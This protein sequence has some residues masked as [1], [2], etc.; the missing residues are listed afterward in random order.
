MLLGWSPRRGGLCLCTWGCFLAIYGVALNCLDLSLFP[1]I[2]TGFGNLVFWHWP[3]KVSFCKWYKQASIRDWGRQGQQLRKFR[4]LL[5]P[6]TPHSCWGRKLVPVAVYLLTQAGSVADIVIPV[7][8]PLS[9]LTLP[10][11]WHP[12]FANPSKQKENRG[13][14]GTLS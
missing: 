8:S 7:S 1:K 12:L 10:V 14:N 2:H 13:E 9:L 11:K 3:S 4:R 5:F 6:C